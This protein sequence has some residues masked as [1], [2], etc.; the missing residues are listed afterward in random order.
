MNQQLTLSV[1]IRDDARFANYYAGP[2]EQIVQ[3]LQQWTVRGNP[4]FRGSR[5]CFIAGLRHYAEGLGHQSV[6]LPLDELADYGPADGGHGS[7]AVGGTRPPALL[8]APTG[9][10]RYFT[11]LTEFRDRQSFADRS[12]RRRWVF[13]CRIYSHD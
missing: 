8:A 6:Y 1:A 3:A 9:K 5:G 11:C 4:I 2:N 13:S 10:R 12:R 7:P